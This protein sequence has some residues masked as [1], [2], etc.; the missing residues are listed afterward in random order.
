M[1]RGWIQPLDFCSKIW[2]IHFN[3]YLFPKEK[4]AASQ[5]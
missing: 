2:S 4:Q 3:H 5:I 1:S